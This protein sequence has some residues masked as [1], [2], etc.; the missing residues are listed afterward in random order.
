MTR[1]D[2]SPG[3]RPGPPT[4][5]AA[6][7]FSLVLPLAGC[8]SGTGGSDGETS[9]RRDSYGDNPVRVRVEN[10]NWRAIHVYAV[11]GGQIESLGQ[12][13]SQQTETYEVPATILGSRQEIRLFADPIGSHEGTLSDPVLIHP[14]DLVEWTLTQPLIHSHIFV[15]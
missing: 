4:W 11:A 14:G 10:Q 2:A 9:P 15:K 1:S 8:M 7:V 5:L 3:P 6:V 13:S 12:L